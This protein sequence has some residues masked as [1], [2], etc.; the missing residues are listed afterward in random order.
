MIVPHAVLT[1][2]LVVRVAVEDADV[3]VRQL[4]GRAIPVAD[5]AVPPAGMRAVVDGEPVAG[6]AAVQVL[7]Y[8]EY[9]VD[10]YG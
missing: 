3:E 9:E 2:I 8:T 10:G 6:F 5:G 4:E 1:Q 7:A